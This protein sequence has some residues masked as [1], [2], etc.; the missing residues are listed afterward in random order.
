MSF[1]CEL[2]WTK[3]PRVWWR[4]RSPVQRGNFDGEVTE[5]APRCWGVLKWLY[6]SRCWVGWVQGTMF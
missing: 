6:W 1:V 3:E 4:S 5:V 2:E